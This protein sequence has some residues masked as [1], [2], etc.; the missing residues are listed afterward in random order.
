M[1]MRDGLLETVQRMVY[2]LAGLLL[3]QVKSIRKLIST[4]VASCRWLKLLS[5]TFK[6]GLHRYSFGAVAP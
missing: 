6:I 1:K 2:M 5:C 4:A 3:V